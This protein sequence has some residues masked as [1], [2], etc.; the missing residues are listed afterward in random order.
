MGKFVEKKT[1]IMKQKISY[2]DAGVDIEKAD[3]AIASSKETIQAT[4]TKDVL[5]SVG[6][7]GSMYSLKNV[8]KN[9]DDPVMVQSVDGV[10]TKVSVAQRCKN[11]S[12]I[13]TD[14]VSACCN[15]VAATG[16]KPIT[17]LDYI[18][19]SALSSDIISEI[20][21]SVASECKRLEV[22]LVGGETA[23]MPGTYHKN[24]YDLVGV[25]TG[26]VD[27]KNIIDGSKTKSGSVVLGLPSNGLHTNGYSL[28]RKLI[29]DTLGLN[30]RDAL[31]NQKT[32]VEHALLAPHKNYSKV[33]NGLIDDGQNIEGIAHITGGG[34][35]DNIPRI[36]PDG[37]AAEISVG[38][39]KKIPIFKFLANNLDLS[40]K[41]LYR[42][43]N[44]GIGLA[45]VVEESKKSTMMRALENEG[46]VEIGKII[47]GPSKEVH[48]N[49]Q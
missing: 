33:I 43:F 18:A 19:S 15:D 47:T 26:V 30:P 36:L 8:L 34:L 25:A 21:K 41:E 13:G 45:L 23:E 10:G 27:K 12:L 6:G 3:K 17:F 35:I 46:C 44:M 5:S 39:W 48:L 49:A 4:F 16:A 9:Y 31:P 24:E 11:F 29:F 20:I 40:T 37:L 7:F 42:T 32:T 28:A 2:K 1:V 22:S 38:A 14:L